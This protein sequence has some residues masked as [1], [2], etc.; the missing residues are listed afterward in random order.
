MKSK[1]IIK[2]IAYFVILLIVT[3]FAFIAFDYWNANKGLDLK[4]S[5]TLDQ[6]IVVIKTQ[7]IKEYDIAKLNRLLKNVDTTKFK[8][9]EKIKIKREIIREAGFQNFDWKGTFSDV[10]SFQDIKIEIEDISKPI[11]LYRRGY[12]NEQTG[13]F[14]LGR[15]WSNKPRS[16]QEARD[17]LAILEN[18]GNPL[19]TEYCIKVPVGIR[20][21]KGKASP[22]VFKNPT[23]KVIEERKGGGIQYFI[24]IVNKD[25]LQ[26]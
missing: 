11:L 6:V 2:S 17:D 8:E 9:I 22:Q 15:W 10:T 12:P 14:G 19:T 16:I 7:G 25:W 1:N 13:S 18:W 4:D 20:V 24:N 23:G 26:K 3:F 21:L 5:K